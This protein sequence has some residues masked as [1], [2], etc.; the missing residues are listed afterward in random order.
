MKWPGD[1]S[2]LAK[3]RLFF[4]YTAQ[5]NWASPSHAAKHLEKK[6]NRQIQP[7]SKILLFNQQHH[8]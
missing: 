3:G 5:L 2:N 7:L 6:T 8:I 4:A 1:G